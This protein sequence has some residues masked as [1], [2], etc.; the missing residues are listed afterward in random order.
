VGVF[1]KTFSSVIKKYSKSENA[2][3]VMDIN[4][5]SRFTMLLL[6]KLLQKLVTHSYNVSNVTKFQPVYTFS[7]Y[8][9]FVEIVSSGAQEVVEFF[10]RS[11]TRHSHHR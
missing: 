5:R 3:F 6:V 8:Q 10:G 1:A 9:A 2:L 7:Y 11:E 4:Q